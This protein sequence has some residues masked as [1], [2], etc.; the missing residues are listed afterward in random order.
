[1]GDKGKI[2]GGN[3]NKKKKVENEKKVNRREKAP[4][5]ERS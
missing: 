5:L 2:K 3:N 1:M 4:K